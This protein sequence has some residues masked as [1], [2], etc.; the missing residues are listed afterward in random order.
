[1]YP[2]IKHLPIQNYSRSTQNQSVKRLK[3][4]R[5]FYKKLPSISIIQIGQKVKEGN[6]KWLQSKKLS[7][8]NIELVDI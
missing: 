1:M 3:H 8:S 7:L 6:V 2:T 4:H 5:A